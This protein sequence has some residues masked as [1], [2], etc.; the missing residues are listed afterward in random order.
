MVSL[1]ERNIF[2]EQ[3]RRNPNVEAFLGFVFPDSK[4]LENEEDFVIDTDIAYI[5]FIKAISS[6]DRS[7]FLAEYN[8]ISQRT[9]SHQTPFI[10]NDYLL[11]VIAIGVVKFDVSFDWFESVLGIRRCETEECLIVTRT[12][13][14][15]IG[16]NY[17][18]LDNNFSIIITAQFF[19]DESLV[20]NINKQTCYKAITS[21][22]FPGYSSTFLNI[23]DLKAYDILI[24]MQLLDEN[25]DFFLLKKNIELAK[26]RVNKLAN[27]IYIFLYIIWMISIY[28]LYYTVPLLQNFIQSSESIFGFIGFGGVL[29]LIFK[30][31][32]IVKFIDTKISEFL[33]NQKS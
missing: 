28:Y 31:E 4:T 16:K 15:L 27:I 13:R 33:F 23:L 26:N 3:G 10:S 20:N 5:N 29:A 8:K 9:P 6:N 19:L 18:S 24:E 11:F 22:P 2:L 21:K 30:K 25:G 7:L 12:F 32:V 17:N 1:I 14:N